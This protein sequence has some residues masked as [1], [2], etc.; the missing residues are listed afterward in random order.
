MRKVAL[1][2]IISALLVGCGDNEQAAISQAK[3]SIARMLKDPDSAKFEDVTL[4]RSEESVDNQPIGYVCGYVNGKNAFGAYAGSV[5]FVAKTVLYKSGAIV[6]DA[7]MDTGEDK[8]VPGRLETPFEMT[9]WNPRCVIGYDP[10]K[11]KIEPAKT[12]AS[13]VKWS[14]ML[15]SL[16][17]RDKAEKI[18]I[19]VESVGIPSYIK[20][21]DGMNMV[22]SG[23]FDDRS[24]AEEKMEEIN[25]KIKFRGF[26]VR[27][28]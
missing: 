18:K 23:P 25:K 13:N 21:L 9:F 5:R 1:I 6:V 8:F 17:S 19:S 26:I 12:D 16:S 2:F 24:V 22:Y 14:V 4:K 7:Q 10:E 15:A 28:H 20:E 3:K 27:V 11:Y